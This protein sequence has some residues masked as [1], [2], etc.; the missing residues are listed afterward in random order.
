MAKP[1]SGEMRWQADCTNRN[2][3][4]KQS[5]QRIKSDNYLPSL[6]K[7][8]IGI[9]SSDVTNSKIP[10]LDHLNSEKLLHVVHCQHR[11]SQPLNNGSLELN[12]LGGQPWI[13]AMVIYK[14]TSILITMFLFFIF[15][16]VLRLDRVVSD[17]SNPRLWNRSS[18]GGSPAGVALKDRRRWSVGAVN[19][20]HGCRFDRLTLKSAGAAF[21][22]FIKKFTDCETK[23]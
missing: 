6:P 13:L 5:K 19:V 21:L 1:L 4:R 20:V 22:Q 16:R 14:N 8:N 23:H 12:S 18:T 2:R 7:N 17:L 11:G 15:T 10:P 9:T 3:Y